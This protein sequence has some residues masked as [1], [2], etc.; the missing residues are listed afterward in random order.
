[1]KDYRQ[2][3]LKAAYLFCE[4]TGKKLSTAGAMA[5]NDG[6]F[7]K[8]LINGAGCTMDRYLRVS[9]WL[10]ENTPKELNSER[11]SN[12]KSEAVNQIRE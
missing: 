7:F 5:A 9:K 6:K 11:V 12:G 8:S 4:T 1:M 2:D 3:L 10:K